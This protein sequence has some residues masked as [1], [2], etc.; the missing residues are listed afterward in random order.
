VSVFPAR[1]PG[2][3][4]RGNTVTDECVFVIDDDESVRRS[5]SRLLKT[6]GWRVETFATAGAF[7]ESTPPN[8]PGCLVLDL[9]LPGVSGLELQATLMRAGRDIPIVFIT[10]H[11]DVP[12]SVRA[13]KGGAV[14]FLQKPFDAQELLDCVGRAL[15][16]NREQRARRAER[17]VVEARFATLTPREREVLAL[18]V[19]GKLNKQ[20]AGDLGIAEKTIKVHRGRVMTKMQAGSVAELV[21]MVEKLGENLGQLPAAG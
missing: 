5:L 2:E 18:V 1:V 9:Q 11:G 19:T 12:S 10:G 21:R 16:R 20:I 8:R 7:L 6:A 15:G 13:M 14:D 17:E 3:R 4:P